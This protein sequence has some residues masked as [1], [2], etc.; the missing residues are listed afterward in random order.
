MQIIDKY[1]IDHEMKESDACIEIDIHGVINDELETL[2]HSSAIVMAAN[3]K[4][5]DDYDVRLG[6]QK[7]LFSS[8]ELDLVRGAWL[9]SRSPY[10]KIVEYIN[11]HR[12][13]SFCSGST[14][15]IFVKIDNYDGTEIE[16]F[17]KFVS[18][19]PEIFLREKN[20]GV[21]N[22]I[23]SD[24]DFTR[25]DAERKLE[26]EEFMEM[27]IDHGIDIKYLD[28]NDQAIKCI[29]GLDGKEMEWIR[30]NVSCKGEKYEFMEW[31]Q[32]P[33]AVIIQEIVPGA[34]ETPVY[35]IYDKINTAST[36]DPVKELN[37]KMEYGMKNN[38]LFCTVKACDYPKFL[39]AIKESVTGDVF[40]GTDASTITVGIMPKDS[41][42]TSRLVPVKMPGR[43]DA[44]KDGTRGN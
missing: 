37:V 16:G 6:M 14:G 5:K 33:N 30:K 12:E 29:K 28:V 1:G 9:G 31:P 39:E 41:P 35:G 44:V 13:A 17:K 3:E 43:Q 38:V 24:R 18:T 2:R 21:F 26:P 25:L 22:V 27:A 20:S 36:G 4:S 40:I 32:Y 7:K 34:R 11:D 42:E 23:S 10:S 15:G 8:D 19:I